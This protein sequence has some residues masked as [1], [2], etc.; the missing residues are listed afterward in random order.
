M[1][2][3]S[4]SRR[5][6]HTATYVPIQRE[7]SVE[8]TPDPRHIPTRV[9]DKLNYLRSL[10]LRRVELKGLSDR[11]SKTR[12]QKLASDLTAIRDI[13][14]ALVEEAP[15]AMRSAA[16]LAPFG[17]APLVEFGRLV[18]SGRRQ[19]RQDLVA[20]LEQITT[21]YRAQLKNTHAVANSGVSLRT[22][23]SDSRTP[24]VAER[25]IGDDRAGGLAQALR[26]A[27]SANPASIELVQEVFAQFVG[28]SV[29]DNRTS[30]FDAHRQRAV[31]V[32]LL[33]AAE[34]SALDATSGFEDRMRIDPVGRLHLERLEMTPVGLERG[35]LVY[36]VPLAPSETVNISHREWSIRTEEFE[37]LIQDVFEDFSEEGVTEKSELAQSTATQTR[38]ASAYSL[39]AN[40]SGYGVSASVNYEA[41][42]ENEL[43]KKD[44]RNQSIAMTR[45]ASARS[46]RDHKQ[47]FKVSSV[48]GTEDMEVRVLTNPSDTEVMRVE[49][50][51][52]MRKWK[53]ELRRYGLRMTYDIAIPNP[54]A[55]LATR[56]GEI[57][58]LDGKI[59][60]PFEFSL[61]VDAIRPDTWHAYAAEYGAT[62]NGPPLPFAMHKS[63][64]LPMKSKDESK[65]PEWQALEFDVDRDYVVSNG[66]VQANFGHWA[67]GPAPHFDVERDEVGPVTSGGGYTS[68][69]KHLHGE[70]G[71][72]P[73]VYVTE[74]IG[75]GFVQASLEVS[76]T[77]SALKRWQSD[78]WQAMR[79]SAEESFY[80]ERQRLIDKRDGLLKAVAGVDAL[81]LRRMEREEIM[82]AVLR[83]LFGPEF[84]LVPETIQELFDALDSGRDFETPVPT[85]LNS[86][87]RVL[88]FGEFIK[89]IHQAIEWESILYFTYPYFWDSPESW[90]HKLFMQHPNARHQE[91]LR[92]GSARVVL[93]IREGYERSF[94]EL[95]EAGA[96]GELVLPGA[97]TH[98][99]L[100]IADEI[101]NYAETNYPGIPAANPADND[102]EEAVEAGERGVLIG[103][104][105]EFTPT[106]ALDISINSSLNDLL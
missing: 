51:Q 15:S 40:Y 47:S 31:V 85:T 25:P 68:S 59:D 62:V 21:W 99:Y 18:S 81:T 7:R 80:L 10:E 98:P 8:P 53:V 28:S 75:S 74:N 27:E 44:S 91:F 13:A 4:N 60:S 84:T 22:V 57:R 33:A 49:Y 36:T 29:P 55:D 82:K 14:V 104:W 77:P 56:L 67:A 30:L 3:L 93:T 92:A 46:K 88:K 50:Y 87:E 32:D 35:E 97:G 45:K 38:H 54:G 42:S 2:E 95:M 63:A 48:V 105:Y 16:R 89:F 12:D 19:L 78:T 39:S 37:K 9:W 17:V 58:D 76:P 23:A 41:N 5:R 86:W 24:D 26:W 20:S 79:R 103:R 34:K 96:F 6:L 65:R 94:T 69:L 61:P 102:D 11:I 73:V 70:S 90:Q 72:L 71:R 1:P 52:L 83:W 43:A 66:F 64:A 100:T 101:R 106:S